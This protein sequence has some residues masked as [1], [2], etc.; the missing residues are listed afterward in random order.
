[1]RSGGA[2]VATNHGAAAEII[3]N[4]VDGLL[5]EPGD[6]SALSEAIARLL[7]DRDLR[8][9]ISARAALTVERRFTDQR[10]RD[11]VRRVWRN[12]DT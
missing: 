6:A 10:F 11:D 9:R 5:V 3:T 1:M 8:G 4:G 12:R 7:G 2:V